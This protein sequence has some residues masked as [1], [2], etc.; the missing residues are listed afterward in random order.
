MESALT[1]IKNYYIFMYKKNAWKIALLFIISGFSASLFAAFHFDRDTVIIDIDPYAEGDIIS[2]TLSLRFH[3]TCQLPGIGKNQDFRF[4]ASKH[5]PGAGNGTPTLNHSTLGILSRLQLKNIASTVG[6]GKTP[7]TIF[8]SNGL[9][10]GW[11]VQYK[12]KG[13]N[14]S[15]TSNV[16]TFQVDIRNTHSLKNLKLGEFHS[17]YIIGLHGEGA[18]SGINCY[19]SLEVRIR[20]IRKTSLKISKLHDVVLKGT[21]ARKMNFCVY[22]AAGLEYNLMLNGRHTDKNN[23]FRMSN[24]AGAYTAYTIDFRS[25]GNTSWRNNI[26]SGIP[27]YGGAASKKI[28]C[29]QWANGA[30]NQL[31]IS[32]QKP[33]TSGIFKDTVTVIVIAK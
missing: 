30:N 11:S 8:P 1:I 24:N 5:N 23:Q 14:N 21:R 22:S 9:K 16:A 31:R 29:S 17:F 20:I 25:R 32:A 6:S 10:K 2:R 33:P 28:E 15:R 26:R 7:Y 18:D 3:S 19:S 12:L 4:G 27:Y 13:K